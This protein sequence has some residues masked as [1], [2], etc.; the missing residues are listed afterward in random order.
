MARRRSGECVNIGTGLDVRCLGQAAT[1][2]VQGEIG[3]EEKGFAGFYMLDFS[4]R[5]MRWAIGSSN[6]TADGTNSSQF[7]SWRI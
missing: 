6:S 4:V 5:A 7:G 1:M 2:T 3:F